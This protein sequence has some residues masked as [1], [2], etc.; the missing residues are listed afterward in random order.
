[1]VKYEDYRT[2]RIEWIIDCKNIFNYLKS[3]LSL[4]VYIFHIYQINNYF[5]NQI[6]IIF[7]LQERHT[8]N[9][10]APLITFH[11]GM[12]TTVITMQSSNL[13]MQTFIVHKRT[14]LATIIWLQMKVAQLVSKIRQAL[15]VLALGQETL[16]QLTM[17]WA[18]L[19]GMQMPQVPMQIPVLLVQPQILKS[20]ESYVIFF[21]FNSHAMWI[22]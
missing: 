9:H 17:M 1:M 15:I 5:W 3:C 21:F 19:T 16:H 11:S 2:F 13:Q 6:N 18:F 10:I 14:L 12:R 20:T 7:C 22:S 4:L 8:I